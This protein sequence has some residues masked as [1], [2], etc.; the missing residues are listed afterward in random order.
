MG[1]RRIHIEGRLGKVPVSRLGTARVI[2]DVLDAS[3]LRS[4][5]DR[6]CV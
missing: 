3:D 4:A 1:A 6:S 5:R 2:D